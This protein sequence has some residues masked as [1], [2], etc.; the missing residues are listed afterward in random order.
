M[1]NLETLH[2]LQNGPRKIFLYSK[3]VRPQ[4]ENISFEIIYE[5]GDH[6]DIRMYPLPAY[7][8]D[9]IR[10]YKQQVTSKKR[11]RYFRSIY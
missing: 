3:E 1:V 4:D 8:A 10:L 5:R 11:R 2:Y 7:V 6:Y 9:L